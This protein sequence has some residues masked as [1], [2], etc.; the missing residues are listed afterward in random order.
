MVAVG[1]Q[2]PPT[3]WTRF[4][5]TGPFQTRGWVGI[6]CVGVRCVFRDRIIALGQERAN[7]TETLNFR[8]G[9]KAEIGVWSL[10]RPIPTKNQGMGSFDLR[11]LTP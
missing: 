4:S 7:T 5:A 8:L 9:R 10:N 2:V 1:E 3:F 11:P 6:L